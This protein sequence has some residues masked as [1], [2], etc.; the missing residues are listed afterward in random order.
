MHEAY[1]GYFQVGLL[2]LKSE[3]RKRE[4]RGSGKRKTKFIK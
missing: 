3:S 2:V 4:R 1:T